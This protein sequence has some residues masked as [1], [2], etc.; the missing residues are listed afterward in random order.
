MRTETDQ[1]M[2]L[3]DYAPTPYVIDRIDLD[4]TI[5]PGTARIRAILNVTPRAGTQPGTLLRLRHEGLPHVGTRRRGD[6]LVRV[7]VRIPER[8]SNEARRAFETLRSS[9]S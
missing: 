2:F 3:R 7:D 9:P 6:V 4:V 8:L 5:A 1:M